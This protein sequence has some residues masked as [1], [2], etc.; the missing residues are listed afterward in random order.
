M[1]FSKEERCL[2]KQDTLEM[3]KQGVAHAEIARELGRS[4]QYIVNLKNELV[5]EGL[6]T[7]DEIEKARKDA[8]ARK[9]NAKKSASEKK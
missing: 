3:L 8:I 1:K 9:N 4:T 2:D 7:I 5:A 6:I